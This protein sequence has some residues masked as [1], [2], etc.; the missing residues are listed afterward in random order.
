MIE[1]CPKDTCTGCRMCGDICPVK[2]ISFKEDANGHI[3][4]EIDQQL[5][6]NCKK[7]ERNCPTNHPIIKNNKPPR[8]IACWVKDKVKRKNSTSGALSFILSKWMIEREGVFIGVTWDSTINNAR[9]IVVDDIDQLYKC[10]GSKYSHSDTSGIYKRVQDY[11]KKGI[12]VLFTG[13]PCQIAA[14][15]SFLGKDYEYLYTVGLVCHGVP[16]RKLLRNRIEQIEEEYGHCVID[17]KSRAK[18]PNQYNS[19]CQ[20]TLDNQEKV[21]IS[22]FKDFFFRIFVTNYGLRPNCFKCP[23]SCSER[24]EDLTVADFWGYNPHSLKYRSFRRGTSLVLLNTEK[25][26]K[27]FQS[28]EKELVVDYRS[29][30][31]AQSC[32][33]NLIKPQLKPD[34]YDKFWQDYHSGTDLENLSLKYAPPRKYERN[35]LTK[36]KIFLKMIIPTKLYVK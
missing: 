34:D 13:T 19:S 11:L 8:A 22:V 27:M 10:Q 35:L 31:E 6:I 33:Q 16:S 12:K 14:L 3:Y 17:Y 26:Q 36:F 28:I 21:H 24:V 9:H 7:C 1:I 25:G 5:C 30:S 18:T 2:A 32:N 20:Y 23:Y 4:P 29:L 15:K